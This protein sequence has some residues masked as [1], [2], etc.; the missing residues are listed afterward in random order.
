MVPVRVGSPVLRVPIPPSRLWGR[1][2]V[3][4]G[5]LRS[6]ALND[7]CS[8]LPC[9]QPSVLSCAI[10]Y[11]PWCRIHPLLGH[12]SDLSNRRSDVP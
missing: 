12:Q 4:Q 8:L 9:P 2:E 6:L 10:L 7:A 3:S 11:V 5:P 1:A